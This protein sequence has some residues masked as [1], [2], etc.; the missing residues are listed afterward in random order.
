MSDSSVYLPLSSDL[1]RP[2][3][4]PAPAPAVSHRKNH[5]SKNYKL[6]D[7]AEAALVGLFSPLLLSSSKSSKVPKVTKKSNLHAATATH[8]TPPAVHKLHNDIPLNMSHE[9]NHCQA[10]AFN[11]VFAHNHENP[12]KL[13][14]GVF[15]F[16]VEGSKVK[17]K[18]VR[19]DG[20]VDVIATSVVDKFVLAIQVSN[21]DSL[22]TTSARLPR[23]LRGVVVRFANPDKYV[24]K[25][26]SG[27]AYEIGA[28]VNDRVCDDQ[29][30]K[31]FIASM[32]LAHRKADNL[33][34]HGGDTNLAMKAIL[35]ILPVRTCGI[36]SYFNEGMCQ[37][38]TLGCSNSN[39]FAHNIF[40][41]F[42]LP[43]KGAI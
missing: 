18:R 2:P 21:P 4:P 10:M 40:C 32:T 41:V 29:V 34:E 5:R 20:T 37:H 22:E 39:T 17:E 23:D 28:A 31:N 30:M 35:F 42:G 27:V 6:A 19:A 12:H 36:N 38:F 7:D 25:H 26:R 8:P 3:S 15:F 33:Y 1:S 16:K 9:K 13:P 43:Q 14:N 11:Q 24:H